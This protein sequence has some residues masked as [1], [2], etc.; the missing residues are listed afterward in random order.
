MARPKTRSVCLA[1]AK[2]VG[3]VF[4]GYQRHKRGH[5][6]SHAGERRSG[7]GFQGGRAYGDCAGAGAGR[8]SA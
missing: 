3:E 5:T 1:G 6:A 8:E 2:L 7:P 4:V